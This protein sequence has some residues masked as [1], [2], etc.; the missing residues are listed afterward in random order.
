MRRD[1]T[2]RAVAEL[3]ASQHGA[4]TRRQAAE[5]GESRFI[6]ARKL[7]NGELIEPVPGVV[8]VSG[9]PMSYRARLSIATL[10]G[11]GT[12][13]THRASAHL[14]GAP[15]FGIAPLETTVVRG[16]YPDIPDVVVHRAKRIDPLDVVVVDGIRT[17]SIA[18][19]LCDLGA[20]V[21][22][23]TVE[24]VLD[25]A[26]YRGIDERWVRQTLDR[27]R[28]PGPS[29]TATLDRVLNDPRRAG[30]IP[31]T[32]FERLVQ[33][34]A[35]A[36]DLPPLVLQHP[37]HHP[38]TGKRLAVVDGMFVEWR[39]ALEAHSKQ[40]HG[41][42]R[43]WRDLER[44]NKLKAIGIDVVYVTWMLAQRPDELLGLV[45]DTHQVRVGAQLAAESGVTPPWAAS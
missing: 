15:D 37:I 20:V 36:P 28:R 31:Q 1:D 12:V 2:M 35:T 33:R 26:L 6:V 32:F 39:I 40:W 41:G 9:S 13:S 11:G 43:I 5:R 14:H 10:A 25:W 27:V 7:A 21:D 17:T 34:A 18:R 30:Q 23:D 42:G 19:M 44:D 8:F 16:R 4:Y 29:G 38:V 45:R 3:A 24:K 22:Q